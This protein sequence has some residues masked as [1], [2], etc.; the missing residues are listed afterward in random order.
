MSFLIRDLRHALRSQRRRPALTLAIVLTLGPGF[1]GAIIVFDL[2]NLVT[3]RQPPVSQPSEVVEIYT[4]N[5]QGPFGA[6]GPTS[7]PD[8]LDYQSAVGDVAHLV[9]AARHTAELQDG[10]VSTRLSVSAVTGRYFEVLGLSTALGRALGP[11]DDQAGA[12]PAVVLSHRAWQRYLG[13]NPSCLG[14]R[15]QLDGS[16]FTVVGV[17][18]AG[19]RGNRIGTGQDLF[20]AV[21]QFPRVTGARL[22]WLENRDLKN[23]D[24]HAR[25][26]SGA[27][28]EQLQAALAVR[29]RQLDAEHPLTN[30]ERRVSVRPASMVHPVDVRELMPTLAFLAA[31]MGL[32]LLIACANV[33]QLLLAQAIS[34]CRDVGIR[35]ALGAGRGRL[36]LDS[37]AESLLLSLLG[38]LWG[39]ALA[40]WGRSLLARFIDLGTFAALRFD[41]RVLGLGLITCLLVTV[42][43][44]LAP[45][46]LSVRADLVSTLK[47]GWTARGRGKA[48]LASALVVTQIALSALLL[49]TTGL[50]GRSLWHLRAANPGFATDNLVYATIW[51]RPKRLPDL[52]R[53]L[54][55]QVAQRAAALP[56]V[57]DVGRAQLLPPVASDLS[58]R[59]RLQE[60]PEPERNSRFNVVDGGYFRTLGIPTLAGRV[61]DSR[62][63]ADGRPAVVVNRVLADELWPEGDP[64]GRTIW[65]EPTRPWEPGP[66]HEVIGVVGST[67][68]H[69]RLADAEPILYFAYEQHYRPILALA[70]RTEDDPAPAMAAL[71]REVLALD[72]LTERLSIRTFESYAWAQLSQE[73]LTTQ[74]LGVFAVLGWFLAIV[75]IAGVMS[76]AVNRE[77]RE[78]GIR[79][80]IGARGQDILRRILGQ[81]LGLTA[82]GLAVGLGVFLAVSQVLR[83]QLI[84]VAAVDP[85]ILVGVALVLL[86]SAALA[87]YVPAR[88]ASKVDPLDALRQE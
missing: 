3:W 79:M 31:A 55:R 15:I 20:I 87:V 17:V 44:G 75:G 28:A 47:A 16:P 60:A 14:Q 62:D 37:L 64:V 51:A 8:F 77:V 25:L 32:L 82:A 34:R 46:L 35:R 43:C 80:A 83:Q 63:G 6:W 9:A 88:R 59:F 23:F 78:I 67:R 39:L 38:G 41:H 48:R 66:A 70:L 2:I 10:D 69:E 33:A 40:F 26:R 52:G 30:L 27:S 13:G 21:A 4:A 29:A 19:F 45:A 49:A 24:L 57:T 76:F 12:P 85:A 22:A 42:L 81:G 71:R 74:A 36:V 73:R 50:V 65:A 5:P 7:Y 68:Q 56:G 58:T 84:G 86:G 11:A 61:F 53:S 54:Y 72:P 1:G 18:A